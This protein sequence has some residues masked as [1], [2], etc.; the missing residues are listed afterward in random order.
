[1]CVCV[2]VFAYMLPCSTLGPLMKNGTLMS[3]SY[4]ID[5]PA[6]TGESRITVS[7]LIPF[8]TKE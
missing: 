2:C 3:N 1:M 6:D 8:I 4:G 7:S 5:L